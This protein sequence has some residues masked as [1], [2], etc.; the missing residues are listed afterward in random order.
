MRT[1]Q[2]LRRQYQAI[3]KRLCAPREYVMFAETP[4]HDGSPHVEHEGDELIYVVTERGARFEE[5]RTRDPDEL[6]FWLVSDLTRQ[7]ALDFELAHRVESE[8][9]RRQWFAKHLELLTAVKPEWASRKKREYDELLVE[10][11]YDDDKG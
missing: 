5:R 11:P 8:D 1:I 2:R 9:S 6:L 10:H 7:M 4:Q 3:A